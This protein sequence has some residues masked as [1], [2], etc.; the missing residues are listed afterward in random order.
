MLLNNNAPKSFTAFI[1]NSNLFQTKNMNFNR[2]EKLANQSDES[3]LAY[4]E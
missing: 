1:A 3:L 2:M 4:N